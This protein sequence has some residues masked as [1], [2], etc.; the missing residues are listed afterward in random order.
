MQT[1]HDSEEQI[2]KLNP[3]FT[4]MVPE[5]MNFWLCRFVVEARKRDGSD[6]PPNTL[7]QICCG[8]NGALKHGDISLFDDTKFAAFTGSLDAK[9][10][11][12]K[13]TGKYEQKRAS[14]ITK[15]IEKFA[16]GKGLL[17]RLIP[18]TSARQTHFLSGI[19]PKWTRPPKTVIPSISVTVDGTTEWCCLS[20]IL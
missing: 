20:G 7:Y 13:S 18:T 15:E 17:R 6:Y 16:L 4:V 11:Q 14:V 3:D 12:L 2:Y 9:M 19:V 8:L 10:K 1:I 5:A